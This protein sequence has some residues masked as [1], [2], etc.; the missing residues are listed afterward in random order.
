MIT[1]QQI[2]EMKAKGEL[3]LTEHTFKKSV[4]IH[5]DPPQYEYK[6]KRYYYTEFL[7]TYARKPYIR[8]HNNHAE[9]PWYARYEE[10]G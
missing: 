6:G 2:K 4:T 5:D 7:L 8:L 10:R 9:I 3:I 1:S